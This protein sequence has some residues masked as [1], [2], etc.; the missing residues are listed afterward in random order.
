MAEPLVIGQIG[1]TFHTAA[2]AVLAEV[3]ES[4]GHAVEIREAPHET[5]YEMLG[6]GEV[7][8]VCSAWLPASHGVYI[9]SY[10]TNLEKLG[11]VYKPYCIWGIPKDAPT[12]ISSV[13]DL[14]RPDV[15]KKFRKRV[16]GITPGAGISRFSRQMIKDYGLEERGFHFE[17]GTLADCTERY[18]DAVAAGDLAVVPL[19][20]PQWLHTET[21]LRELAD[22]K[23]LLGGQDEAT[24]VLRIG[25]KRKVND[26]GMKFLRHVSLGNTLVSKLDRAICRNGLTPRQAAQAWVRNNP[27]TLQSWLG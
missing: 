13:A 11:V 15:A 7:D 24:L 26:R 19:W 6:R 16:Q 23:G 25:A 21:P 10:E 1:L 27:Q 14:A 18:L 20:H 12:D 22:P 3:L 4:L 5:M 2:A 9:A 17:N 8:L